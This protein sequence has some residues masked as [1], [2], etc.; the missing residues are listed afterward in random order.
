[1]SE[2]IPIAPYDV[3]AELLVE[4]L[5][6]LIA[7]EPLTAALRGGGITPELTIGSEHMRLIERIDLEQIV[8]HL[9]GFIAHLRRPA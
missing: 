1:M 8:E 4:R 3:T 6:K 2:P 5:Q 9:Q 7:A